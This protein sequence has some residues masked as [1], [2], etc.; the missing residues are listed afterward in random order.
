MAD[1][2]QSAEEM[3]EQ[4]LHGRCLHVQKSIN[5]RDCGICLTD[6]FNNCATQERLEIERLKKALQDAVLPTGW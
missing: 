1:K 2:K 3:A 6:A 5:S 4:I